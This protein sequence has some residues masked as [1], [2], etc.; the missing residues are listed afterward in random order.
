MAVNPPFYIPRAKRAAGK[1]TAKRERDRRHD[2]RR[3]EANPWR[4]FYKRKAWQQA[5]EAQLAKQ[6]LCERH[7]AR[8]ETVAAT[9]VNHR[10]PHRGDWQLFIDPANH[11][12]ACKHC[13]DS[14][15][16]QIERLGYSTEVNE[17]GEYI[18][19]MHPSNRGR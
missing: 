3:R 13:H 19:P 6:P 7:L 18:D 12:S 8:G 4:N 15:I 10:I 14:I 2:A 5:R 17:R 16:Q 11:E 9:V 1:P